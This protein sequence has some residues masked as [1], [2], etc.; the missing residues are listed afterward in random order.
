MLGSIVNYGSGYVK[1]QADKASNISGTE[2]IS[3]LTG[4]VVDTSTNYVDKYA[5]LATSRQPTINIRTGSQVM[6]LVNRVFSVK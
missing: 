1:D 2:L 3:L 4:S 5:D 6:M